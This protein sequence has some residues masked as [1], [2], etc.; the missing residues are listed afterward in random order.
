MINATEFVEHN[1]SGF[2]SFSILPAAM[3]K[4]LNLNTTLT[5]L[6]I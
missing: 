6:H 2:F 4:I 5:N 3:L 1:P